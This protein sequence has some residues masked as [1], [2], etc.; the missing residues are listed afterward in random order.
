MNT[1]N[2][3]SAVAAALSLTAATAQTIL[4]QEDFSTNPPTDTSTVTW[5]TDNVPAPGS[6]NIYDVYSW[7]QANDFSQNVG[8]DDDQNSSTSNILIPGAL[9][10]NGETADATVTATVILPT[11]L[12]TSVPGTL[13]FF[14]GTRGALGESGTLTVTTQSGDAV[15]DDVD[16]LEPVDSDVWE[17][18]AYSIDLTTAAPGETLTIDWTGGG[19]VDDEF[20]DTASGLHLV[21]INFAVSPV[22]E[23]TST[24][25][26]LLGLALI[27]RRR[28]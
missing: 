28:R 22:P 18:F 11:D 15:I 27:I 21:D 4:I 13:T 7:P 8:Y 23:P 5:T 2:P 1:I 24:I 16:I 19:A 10:V 12:D 25:L 17:F 26:S 6:T 14:A 3:Y 9:E 20:L